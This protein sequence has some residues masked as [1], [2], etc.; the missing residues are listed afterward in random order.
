MVVME[1]CYDYIHLSLLKGHKGDLGQ[2]EPQLR[3]NHPSSYKTNC[4]H[5]GKQALGFLLVPLP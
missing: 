1:L 3:V 5:L 4:I 2:R